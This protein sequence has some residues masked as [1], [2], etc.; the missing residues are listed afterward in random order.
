MFIFLEI[1]FKMEKN[2]VNIYVLSVMLYF[3]LK[4]EVNRGNIG[5]DEKGIG[6]EGC[7]SG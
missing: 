4:W 7:V 1:V 2:L 3:F 5:K 6:L